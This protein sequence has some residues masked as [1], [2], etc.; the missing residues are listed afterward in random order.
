MVSLLYIV[1]IKIYILLIMSDGYY[2]KIIYDNLDKLT[3]KQLRDIVVSYNSMT[4]GYSKNL[5]KSY[6][7]ELIKKL[8]LTYVFNN[9]KIMEI[10]NKY[11][12]K[13]KQEKTR[14]LNLKK[15]YNFDELYSNFRNTN[16]EKELKNTKVKSEYKTRYKNLRDSIR[17]NDVKIEEILREINR[18]QLPKNIDF[19]ESKR[20][21]YGVAK[22][23]IANIK[24]APQRGLELAKKYLEK[25]SKAKPT[26]KKEKKEVKKEVKKEETKP[27]KKKIVK[28]NKWNILKEAYD[29]MKGNAKNYN[30]LMLPDELQKKVYELLDIKEEEWEALVENERMKESSPPLNQNYYPLSMGNIA[31][32]EFGDPLIPLNELK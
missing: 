19:P 25:D 1:V 10:V 18:I 31:V 24:K 13:L 4:R 16:I 2:Q 7:I 29:K 21:I 23:L 22:R 12:P 26:E 5:R 30:R 11:D 27:K 17:E 20:Q 8:P 14:S 6:L 32:N 28:G 15:G 3:S 9:P